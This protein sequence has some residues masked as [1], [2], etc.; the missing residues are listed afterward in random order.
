MQSETWESTRILTLISPSGRSKSLNNT[1][2]R[3][4]PGRENF[5]VTLLVNC[6]V[7]LLILPHERQIGVIPDVELDQ[8]DKWSIDPAFIKDWGTMK[9]GERKTLRLLVRRLRNSVAHFHIEAEGTKQDIERLKF[10]DQNGF[11]AT[12]PVANVKAFLKQFASTIGQ[13]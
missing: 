3:R 10:A 13:P 7:G 2:E 12:I 8:L 9:K 6:F 1:I 5:E 4:R 11:R